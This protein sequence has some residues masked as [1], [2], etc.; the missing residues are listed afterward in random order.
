ML[1]RVRMCVCMCVCVCTRVH[2]CV[3]VSVDVCLKAPGASTCC[4]VR[5][6]TVY[7]TMS[8]T[9]SSVGSDATTAAG[10]MMLKTFGV[11]STALLRKPGELEGGL[12]KLMDDAASLCPNMLR[13]SAMDEGN[14]SEDAELQKLGDT[15]QT[16]RFSLGSGVHY[17]WLKALE[18]PE[19]K[20][21]Y[22]KCGKSHTQIREFKQKWAKTEIQITKKR[23]EQFTEVAETDFVGGR[24]L[25]IS[26]IFDE[27][28][29]DP[30]GELATR[31]L[32]AEVMRRAA[33]G[34]HV[35]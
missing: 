34:T 7:A 27:Q 26:K 32:V 25:T 28:G 8:G 16:G 15:L 11:M 1:A 2:G 19:F 12:T 13:A 22:T 21:E 17:K 10:S 9:G 6:A 30:A 35:I 3:C 5:C 33:A 24:Y 23:K 20:A 18:T 29:R 4:A 14:E 31:N